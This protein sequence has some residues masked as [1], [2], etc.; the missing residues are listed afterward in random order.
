MK[1]ETDTSRTRVDVLFVLRPPVETYPPTL[2][3]LEILDAHGISV[4]VAQ[5]PWNGFCSQPV[6]GASARYT[7]GPAIG[8]TV[9]QRAFGMVLYSLAIRRLLQKL[10]PKIVVTF[11]AEACMAA[12]ALPRRLSSK[13]IWHFHELPEP[14]SQGITVKL[15]NR[16]VWH[17][18]KLPDLTVFPDPGR[19]KVY[20][21]QCVTCPTNIKIVANCP[22]PM[23]SVPPSTLH[24]QLMGKL[25]TGSRVVLYHG[26]IGPNHAL[27]VAI[28]SMPFWPDNWFLVAKGSCTNTYRTTLIHLAKKMGV[29]ERV[30]MFDPGFQSYH[31]HL[32]CVAGAD[33]AWTVLEPTC[34]NWEYSAYASN[35]RF[36][37]IALGIPQITNSGPSM[38]ELFA[39]N[40]CG[41]CISMEDPNTNH[42]I[43]RFIEHVSA[44][45]EL[46]AACRAM[47]L[48][49]FNYD[50][51]YRLVLA[52]IREWLAQ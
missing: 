41:I 28:G 47:H 7:L 2:N 46:S 30:I 21:D 17:N 23:K 13:L 44:S 34:Q 14:Q 11:D 10:K 5:A 26:A 22:R 33:I 50:H 9:L 3:Q 29:K 4:A 52:H 12:G 20:A 15:A 39:K 37:A 6:H 49:E 24:N 42:V 25:P 51:Q 1:H 27:E 43:S 19:A 45:H 36:E 35:K 38:D 40:G 18:A 48:N 8:K 31:D 32:A 16:F